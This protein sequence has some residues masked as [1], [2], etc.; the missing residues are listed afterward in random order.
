MTKR[1]HIDDQRGRVTSRD[2]TP[3]GLPEDRPGA[4]AVVILHGSM[5]SARS[6]TLLA[7]ALAGDFNPS[8]CPTGAGRGMSGPHRPRPQRAHRGGGPAGR[9]GRI[10]CA[11]GPFGVSAGGLVVLEAARHPAPASARSP[12]TS[13]RWPWNPTRNTALAGALR[14][15][16]GQRQGGGRDDHQL[17]RAWNWQP[18]FL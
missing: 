5:E 7:Q 15:R 16:D 10:G 13:P 2:G 9:P 6:H 14:P 8:T 4:R 11:G 1:R 17:V 18:P 12:S 3:I